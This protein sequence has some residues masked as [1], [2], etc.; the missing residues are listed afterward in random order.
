[1]PLVTQRCGTSKV[2]S[3]RSVL[4]WLRRDNGGA[5]I[6]RQF[7]ADGLEPTHEALDELPWRAVHPLRHMLVHL[8]V[9]DERI[10]PLERLSTWLPEVLAPL[11][12]TQR[13][14]VETFAHW[15]LFRRA[16]R[17]AERNRFTKAS[18]RAVRRKVVV[19]VDFLQW[20][21]TQGVPLADATQPMVD[22]WLEGGGA[23]R[24]ELV[25]FVKW[26]HRRRLANP[27]VVPR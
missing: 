1:M 17:R 21:N 25:Y 10:E 6:L 19:A 16:R 15:W 4:E 9:L 20:L 23:A 26:T 13:R 8:G 12:E 24:R 2:E 14:I 11:P 3:P 22:E 7:A 18:G 27:L 5:E